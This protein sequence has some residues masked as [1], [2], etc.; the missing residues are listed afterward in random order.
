MPRRDD[1]DQLIENPRGQ[2]L[3]TGPDGVPSDDAEIELSP[4]H[5][6]LDDL[7]VRDLELDLNPG[8]SRPERRDDR[9]HHVESGRSARPDEQ[10]SVAQTVELGDRLPGAFNRRDDGR[11]VPLEDSTGLRQ[12]HLPAVT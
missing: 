10:R 11:G 2:T 7:R 5:A 8:V 3:L 1:D 6:I 4:L 9:W 12:R